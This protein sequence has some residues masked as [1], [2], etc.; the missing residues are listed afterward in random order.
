M[1]VE[2][3]S[4]DFKFGSHQIIPM[5]DEDGTEFYSAKNDPEWQ[6]S[7]GANQPP[8]AFGIGTNPTIERA[9]FGLHLPDEVEHEA[10]RIRAHGS[11]GLKFGDDSGVAPTVETS[12]WP[13]RDRLSLPE[14]G[15]LNPLPNR[16][17]VVDSF[18]LSWELSFNSGKSWTP[19][20]ATRN[21]LY[22]VAD[23]EATTSRFTL[24]TTIHIGSTG[25]S[26]ATTMSDVEK[27]IWIH[28][29]S[30]DVRDKAG[31]E[32]Y[33]YKA[34]SP[35]DTGGI[36]E[37]IRDNDGRCGHW[38]NLLVWVL[39]AQEIKDYELLGIWVLNIGDLE[40]YAM[41]VKEEALGQGR[42]GIV[43]K[44]NFFF[45]HCLVQRKSD[46]MI[47][48]PSYGISAPSIKLW[49][50]MALK[51]IFYEVLGGIH[52]SG[53]ENSDKQETGPK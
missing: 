20:G 26:G 6:I 18:G 46:G 10:I 1:S 50:P 44:K 52:L 28:F 14:T 24:E 49:E 12:L 2:V 43:P 13:W 16:V 27:A 15:S 40:G 17:G 33:Y 51:E 34:A 11:A 5:R 37:F 25:A 31:D 23:S 21:L 4:V 9:T 29:S 22:L 39:N 8:L 41:S 53:L 7:K 47:F 45:D 30:L 48:D 32:L 36:I 3:E 35:D 42:G 19:I 38:A